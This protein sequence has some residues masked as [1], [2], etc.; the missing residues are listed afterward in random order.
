MSDKNYTRN[1]S[2]VMDF[3]E[4]TMSNGY[5]KTGAENDTA[6]FDVFY[7]KNPD[8]AG[9]AISAGLGQ[10]VEYIKDLHFDDEDIEYFRKQ[11]IFD[12]DFLAYLKKFRFTGDIYAMRE[13]TIIYPNEPII[14]VTANII[15]AQLLET[16]ILLQFNHQSL[17]AT[18]TNRI[19]CAAKGKAVSDFGARRAH[20]FDAAVYGAR[21]AYIGGA[22][23]T[24]T[25]LAG[26]MFDIPIS[27]TMAHSWV[28]R[29]DNEYEAF[30]Q[31]ALTYPTSTV[32]LVDTY[33][34]LKI[35]V[36]NAIRIAREVLEPMGQ[37]LKGIRIDS[38]D[39]AYL[40]K[41]ARKLLDDAG[42]EDC[43]IV[44]SNSLD[45]FTIESL[46]MQGAKIDSYGVGERLIT[47]S[48]SPVF[49]GVYK[50]AEINGKPKMKV[51]ETP[52]KMTN[53][54]RKQVYRVY[55]SEGKATADML[56]LW[57]E[58]I[59]ADKP[60]PFVDPQKYWKEMQFENCTFKKLLQPVFLKG[61][62]VYDNPSVKEI[63]EYVR[64]QLDN[65]IWVEEQRFSNPHTHYLDMTRK[66]YDTKIN[67]LNQTKD[68]K[69]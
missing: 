41:E 3:Y 21:A 31:Y 36:P 63:R 32:L 4:M 44:A 66:M 53:P 64:Y 52:E 9:F 14:S 59:D 58:E 45:E 33:D 49:S 2:M 12:E 19:V 11:G 18:K 68:G 8:G 20:N 25:V 13:G 26:Q 65:E 43:I 5:F 60:V 67:L 69:E 62:C 27:G 54:A 50:L 1:L 39:L 6:T 22:V 51:S 10:I 34:V 48:S 38:G 30:R 16:A 29:F 23:G 28:M 56:A 46:N 7:R 37:R 61:E 17:I 47:S 42:L 40:S 57:D 15:E 24:A 55:D 35:G